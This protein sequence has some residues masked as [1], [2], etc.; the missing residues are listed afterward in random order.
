MAPIVINTNLPQY[1]SA[2]NWGRSRN[3]KIN[4]INGNDFEL[5]KHIERPNYVISHSCHLI[6]DNFPE[7]TFIG[8]ECGFPGKSYYPEAGFDSGALDSMPRI[9]VPADIIYVNKTVSF[10]SKVFIK[11]IESLGLNLKVYGHGFGISEFKSKVPPD[12]AYKGV[13]AIAADNEEEIYKA[14]YLGKVCIT[15]FNFAH[16]YNVFEI[17]SGQSL[18]STEA[19]QDFAK[20]NTWDSIFNRMGILN[21]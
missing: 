2:V 21:E 1:H 9:I 20:Q 12:S 8:P 10:D 15:P 19:Q 14:L 17:E 6:Q 3:I 7:I 4:I 18:V 16:C 13:S 11:K 5:A